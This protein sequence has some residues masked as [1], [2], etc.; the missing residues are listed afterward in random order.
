MNSCQP[1]SLSGFWFVS[2]GGEVARSLRLFSWFSGQYTK[3]YGGVWYIWIFFFKEKESDVS[4]KLVRQE[5][6]TS[7]APFAFW[8]LDVAPRLPGWVVLKSLRMVFI[9]YVLQYLWHFRI[10]LS[11]VLWF[12]C[13]LLCFF[14]RFPWHFLRALVL[15][16][17]VP[18]LCPIAHLL[19]PIFLWYLPGAHPKYHHM[20]SR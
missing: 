4:F 11:Y 6:L 12:I 3:K 13:Y 9:C 18:A 16:P 10:L 20:L 7:L 1:K 8:F 17:V 5:V 19:F 14:A 15:F 2:G